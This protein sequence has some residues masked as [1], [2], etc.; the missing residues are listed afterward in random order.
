[1]KAAE[2]LAGPPSPATPTEQTTP[3]REE[4]SRRIQIFCTFCGQY[5][6]L[7]A[8]EESTRNRWNDNDN[9]Q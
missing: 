7:P 3:S 9:Q 4:K 1:M 5:H 8:S 2:I 6:R